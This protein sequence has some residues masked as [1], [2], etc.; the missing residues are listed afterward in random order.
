MTGYGDGMA[1]RVAALAGGR[2]DRVLDTAPT[3]GRIDR[4]HQPSPARAAA[5]CRP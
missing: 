5:R 2:V 3:G 4:A 1:E